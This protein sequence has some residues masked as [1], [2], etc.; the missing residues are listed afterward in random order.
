MLAIDKLISAGGKLAEFS[1]ETQAALHRSEVDM[2]K[3]GENPVDLGGNASPERFVQALE[4]V[5]ADTNVDAVL[6]V[7]APHEWPLLW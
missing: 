2:S 3:P 5:A 6:V 7:H 4:I 1:A